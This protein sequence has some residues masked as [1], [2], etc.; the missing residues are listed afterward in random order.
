VARNWSLAEVEATVE[1]YLAM[2]AA[3]RE[4]RAYSKTDHRRRLLPLLDGRTEFAV[5]QK[6]RN[7][8]AVLLTLGVPCID[9]Y[10]PLYNY[11]GL[12]AEVVADRLRGAE[13][14]LRTLTEDV[15]GLVGRPQLEDILSAL[16]PGPEQDELRARAK[17]RGR[18]T[19]VVRPSTMVDYLGLEASNASLGLAG[20]EFV[21]NY[22]HA[23]LVRARQP[24]LADRVEHVAK[25]KGDGLGYDIHSFD[26]T[27]KDRL[28]EVKTTK[29]GMYTPIRVTRNEV[30]VSQTHAKDYHLY[31]V[32][33]FRPSPRLFVRSGDLNQVFD[34]E[35]IQF[36][37]RLAS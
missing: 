11:Q 12:L 23:R 6:H 1:D 15:Q 4:G 14:L 22:E 36:E 31:R 5:E 29:Y 35:A 13:E 7:I 37:G 21:L 24:K 28:I 27:G 19:A 34:L 2:L 3:E 9:G 26:E 20:E 33:A 8:S 16:V 30:N 32:F 18:G 25:T 17:K 10:K